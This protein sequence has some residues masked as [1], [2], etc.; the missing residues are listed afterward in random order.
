MDWRS[1]I[2][3]VPAVCRGRAFVMGTRE[4]VF[5]ILDNLADGESADS[6]LLSYPNLRLEDFSA[7]IAYAAELA[8][9]RIAPFDRAG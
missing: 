2:S 3:A 9:E 5:V 4:I 8:R 7:S 6:I 1:R